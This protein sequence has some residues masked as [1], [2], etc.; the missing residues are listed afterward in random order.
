MID[1]NKPLV[2][3]NGK[4]ARLIGMTLN[5]VS[6]F[7]HAVEVAGCI[8]SYKECGQYQMTGINPLD[9]INAPVCE[10][11]FFNVYNDKTL[12]YSYATRKQA[13]DCQDRKP[14]IAVLQI[15]YED[16][17]PVAAHLQHVAM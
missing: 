5:P 11:R 9:L 1:W 12:G 14:R 7:T 2:T 4:E 16:D 13:N 6:T 15:A 3:R 17:V 10:E 8:E